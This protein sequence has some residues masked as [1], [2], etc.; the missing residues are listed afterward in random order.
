MIEM[1]RHVGC[2]AGPGVYILILCFHD[3]PPGHG[4][5]LYSDTRQVLLTLLNRVRWDGAADNHTQGEKE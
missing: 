4:C 2:T 1:I 3:I 5:C